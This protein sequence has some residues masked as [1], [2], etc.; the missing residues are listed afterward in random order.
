MTP[1]R[2]GWEGQS[3]LQTAGCPGL[4]W[5]VQE[6]AAAPSLFYELPSILGCLD[7]TQLFPVAQPLQVELGCGDASF[8]A[9]Y[10]RQNP[11]VN[12]LWRRTSPRPTQKVDRK[13][14][15]SG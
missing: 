14:G 1:R 11:T 2:W 6:T 13:A 9:E 5:C 7:L 8:L 12:F 3:A 15:G 4:N 10:A